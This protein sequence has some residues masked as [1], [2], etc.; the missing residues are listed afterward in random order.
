M[1]DMDRPNRGKEAPDK[2]MPRG[3]TAYQEHPDQVI[4]KYVCGRCKCSRDMWVNPENSPKS[5]KC[6]ICELGRMRLDGLP[7]ATGFKTKSQRWR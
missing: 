6:Q 2:L 1:T 4:R 7:P 5:I 3:A